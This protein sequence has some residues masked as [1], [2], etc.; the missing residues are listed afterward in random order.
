MNIVAVYEKKQMNDQMDDPIPAVS[1][2]ERNQVLK[3]KQHDDSERQQVNPER[4]RSKSF[5]A[6]I[7]VISAGGG[8]GNAL[9]LMITSNLY[10]VEFIATN[11]DIQDL[12]IKSKADIKVQIGAKITNG[13]GA[14]GEPEKGEKA[15][16]ED[17]DTIAEV[18]KGADMV[19]ITAGMGG[20]TG[21]G[22]APIIAKIAKEMGILTV[23]VVTLPFDCEGRY[24]MNLALKGLD[25]LREN[26]DSLIVTRNQ[27]LLKI[28]DSM[29]SYRD[30]FKKADE[31]LCNGVKAISDII[32]KVGYK[33]IDFADVKSVMRNKGDA[34]LSIGR[35]SGSSRAM[36]AVKNAMDGPLIEDTN[37][38]GATHVL[39]N[40]AGPEDVPLIEIN[41][42]INSIR[43]K[44]D[45]DV[46]LIHGILFEPEL[47]DDIQVTVIATGFNSE[48]IVAADP[49]E[50]AKPKAP[51][52]I[53]YNDFVKMRERTKHPEYLHFLPQ[54][55]YQDDLDVPS[56]IRNHNYQA[57]E[58]IALKKAENE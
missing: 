51:D 46:N 41:N 7:K 13:H 40:I 18:L 52:F 33:N 50:T 20:G 12:E 29:P 31:V 56:V 23:A 27:D 15:A 54:R 1:L 28:M 10:G 9:N 24:K 36:D 21:T 44:C 58:K 4:L 49:S 39:I 19:I 6:V 37:I 14:G 22:A 11:T 30:T 32:N 48:R 38:D 26:I 2:R 8:G 17:L 42:I 47:K 35:G 5:P 57:D 3:F 53:D 43:E 25:K 16:L 55:E 34:L 45:P